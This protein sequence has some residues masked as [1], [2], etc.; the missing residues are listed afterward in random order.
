[1][2]IIKELDKLYKE[3][4]GVSHLENSNRLVHDSADAQDFARYCIENHL[5]ITKGSI[6]MND[7]LNNELAVTLY[8]Y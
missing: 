8:G 4:S 2:N 5:A 3:W 7:T 6:T 1:M